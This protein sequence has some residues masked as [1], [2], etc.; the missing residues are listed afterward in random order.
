MGV[1]ECDRSG[2]KHIMCDRLILDD[3]YICVYCFDELMQFKK[4]LPKKMMAADIRDAIVGFM[5][6][7]PGT[8]SE[9][10]TDEEFNRILGLPHSPYEF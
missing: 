7:E 9:V 2:C 1:N 8:Y 4:T 5:K 3:F 10:D 6:T